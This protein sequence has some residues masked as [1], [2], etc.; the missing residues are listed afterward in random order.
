[1]AEP[2]WSNPAEH[3]HDRFP[4]RL[5][6]R[7]DHVITVVVVQPGGQREPQLTAGGLGTQ[8]LGHP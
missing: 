8:S 1:M 6:R 5:I 2:S 7:D 4:D 3:A